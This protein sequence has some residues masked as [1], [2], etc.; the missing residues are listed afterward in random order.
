MGKTS[1]MLI[2]VALPIVVGLLNSPVLHAA[3]TDVVE[4]RN[5]D[6]ITGEVKEL[7]RGL[8]QFKTD[9][10]GTIYIEWDEVAH[11]RSNLLVEVELAS[12]R[13]LF[14]RLAP[15]QDAGRLTVADAEFGTPTEIAI[16]ETIRIA[17]LDERGTW[18]S[19]LDGH[20]NFGFSDTKAT[21]TTQLT[22]DAGLR[23]RDR[24]RLWD[25]AF[26]TIQ[27]DAAGTESG[28]ATLSGESR[29]FFGNRLFWS[30]FLQFSQNDELG[31]NHH[32]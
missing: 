15:S 21:D 6:H 20:I 28:S 11:L 13:R 17:R 23:H 16:G 22:F 18:L 26:S 19:R 32:Y 10:M 12:G 7:Q 5:G 31:L 24:I 30:G 25:F 2:N 8:L 14:G 3:K 27:N 29:R 1:R 9:D 4:L